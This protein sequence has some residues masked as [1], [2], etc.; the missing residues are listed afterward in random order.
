MPRLKNGMA[1]V[2]FLA[3]SAEAKALLAKGHPCASIYER[4]KDAGKISMSYAAF[5]RH[6]KGAPHRK[7]KP[8]EAPEAPGKPAPSAQFPDKTPPGPEVRKPSETASA[9]APHGPRRV[10][11]ASA[12]AVDS[13]GT[14]NMPS[15]ADLTINKPVSEPSSTPKSGEA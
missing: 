12:S 4:F 9:P 3:V 13:W 2:E 5:H 7:T 11:A 14:K 10:G 6:L 15:T 1:R 8:N